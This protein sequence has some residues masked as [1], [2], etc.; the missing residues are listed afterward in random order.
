MLATSSHASF[1][2]KANYIIPPKALEW[3]PGHC[4]PY[5]KLQAIHAQTNI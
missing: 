2:M 5:K 3:T 4:H 1:Y